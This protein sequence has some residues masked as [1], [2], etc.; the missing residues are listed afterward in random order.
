MNGSLNTQISPHRRVHWSKCAVYSFKPGRRLC[1]GRINQTDFSKGI[2][3]GKE[4][5]LGTGPNLAVWSNQRC[6]SVPDL[7]FVPFALVVLQN[8]PSNDS[9]YIIPV[10]LCS[11]KISR[12]SPWN[13]LPLVWLALFSSSLISDWFNAYWRRN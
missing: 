1:M 3:G 7:I 8:R 2:A 5:R 10:A 12:I 13:P 9:N 11:L 6:Q 4:A